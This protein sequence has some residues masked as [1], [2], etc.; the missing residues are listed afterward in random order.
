[1]G[2]IAVSNKILD[3]YFGYLK[4]LDDKAKRI[5]IAKLTKSISTRK[6]KKDFDLNTLFG[7]WEDERDSD[8]IIEDIRSSRIENNGRESFE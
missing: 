2:N 7:A 6:T 3:K 8:E 1:M 5:L 4:S